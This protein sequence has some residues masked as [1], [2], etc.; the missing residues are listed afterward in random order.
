MYLLQVENSL[1]NRIIEHNN[2]I[3]VIT[4]LFIYP[5]SLLGGGGR[6]GGRGEGAHPPL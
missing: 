4:A 6:G 1:Y 3:L 5:I 2:F